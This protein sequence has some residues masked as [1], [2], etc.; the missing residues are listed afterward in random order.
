MPE[1]WRADK[2][3]LVEMRGEVYSPM[4]KFQELNARLNEA[5]DKPFANGATPRPVRQGP[6]R[7]RLPPVHMGVDGIGILEGYSAVPAS[8]GVRP[9]EDLGPAHL[10][11]QPGGRRPGGVGTSSPA[12]REPVLRRA[13]GEAFELD[14]IRLQGRLG[15]T[16]RAPRWAIACKYAPRR[17]LEHQ[18]GEQGGRR[19]H[20]PGRAVRAGEPVRWP[21]QRGEFAALHNQEVVKAKGVLIGD[22]VV[23]R[24]AGDGIPGIPDRW[25]T[26]GTA[27]SGSS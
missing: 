17:R 21:K 27:A 23:L 20:R 15:S 5:G 10:P 3:D 19:P 14:E 2:V 8:P 6:A 18:A 9:A 16:A 13:R 11:A 22:T 4:E 7:H 1:P 12:R 26:S 25:P 24:K